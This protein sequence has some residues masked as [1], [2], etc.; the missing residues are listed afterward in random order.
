MVHSASTKTKEL[1]IYLW[2]NKVFCD[3]FMQD[4]CTRTCERK[5]LCSN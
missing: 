1:K 2:S 3:I 5:M 4:K